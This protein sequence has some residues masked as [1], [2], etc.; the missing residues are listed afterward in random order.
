MRAKKLILSF[1]IL[2]SF[3]LV[4]SNI[5]IN[6]QAKLTS[7]YYARVETDGVYLYKTT[8]PLPQNA[9]FELPRSYF[10]LLLSDYNAIFYKA[11][12]RDIV[13]YV[14]KDEVSPVAET[15]QNPYLENHTFYV[16]S[17]DGTSVMSSPYENGILQ[18][19]VEEQEKISYYGTI[20]GYEMTQNRGS[21][22]IYGKTNDGVYGYIY[23][24]L[25]QSDEIIELNTEVVTVI[26]NPF[27]DNSDDYLY[28][29]VDLTPGLKIL[30]VVLVSI[31]AGVILFLMFRPIFPNSNSKSSL[32]VSKK[33]RKNKTIKQIEELS[34]DTTF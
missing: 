30:L 21:T 14:L 22:W 26:T 11:Q 4:F 8:N 24:G 27:F 32:K 6:S 18:S 12:Y 13:G 3:L 34:D 31:P 9:Y 15:P 33:E 17:S 20:Q 19:V 28:N 23:G 5:N 1:L 10:V 16:F 7:F 2:Y 29:L 25:A